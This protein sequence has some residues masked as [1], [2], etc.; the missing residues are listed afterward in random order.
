M[1]T[2]S[3]STLWVGRMGG[4]AEEPPEALGPLQ[5]DLQSVGRRGTFF[6]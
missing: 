6:H 1:R 2:E 5:L 4:R 3:C